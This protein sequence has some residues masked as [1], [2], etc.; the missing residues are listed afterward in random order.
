LVQ[1]LLAGI[2]Q[3]GRFVLLSAPAGFGKTTLLTEFIARLEKSG[4]WVTL[5]KDDNDPLQ[6]W[7]YIIK[8]LQTVQP[9]IG[10]SA[11]A[12]LESHQHFPNETIPTLIINDLTKD[13]D[14]I[15]LV[16]DDYHLIQNPAIHAGLGFILDHLPWNLDIVVST[17]MDPPWPL[18]RFRAR[19]QLIEIRSMDLR[20]T[21][22][23]ATLFLNEVMKLELSTENVAA[24]EA[25]TEGWIASLQLAALSMKGRKDVPGFIQSFTGSHVY[26][27]EY[28]MDEVLGRQPEEVIRFLLRTSI[29][30]SL[31]ASLGEA[32]ST[33]S[34]CHT[35]IKNLY[36]ANLFI[37][38]LDDEGQWFRYHRLFADLLQARL[39]QSIPAAEIKTLHQRAAASMTP[40]K[41]ADNLVV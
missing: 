23:E 10:K 5:D 25:R 26:V 32:V 39:Q 12:L 9:D 13:P 30:E 11:L 14:E 15:V 3:T 27:A 16:L 4:A 21:F 19:D 31:N 35:I 34:D 8:A 37:L 36:Q 28:L 22:E 33:Q 41:P 40:E 7:T 24:L 20:F 29:L 38:P 17:R 1:K 2:S 6:F 18:A